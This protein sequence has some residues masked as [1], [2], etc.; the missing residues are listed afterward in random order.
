MLFRSVFPLTVPVN[1]GPGF[2]QVLDVP[3]SEII[4]Y[5]GDKSGKFTEAPAAGEWAERVKQLHQELIEHVA[6]S[7]DSLMEKFFSQGGLSEEE[8][9]AGIHKAIQEQVFV[10]L[11]VT[12]AENNIGVARLMDIIAKYGSS[13]VDRKVVKALDAAGKDC[14]EIGRAHV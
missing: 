2:N 14:D 3:R 6:E 10:P 8:M 13:P 9:R 5:A 12:S 11:F 4:T 1:P 7:D